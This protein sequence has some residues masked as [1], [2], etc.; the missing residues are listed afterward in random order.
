MS[1]LPS[2]DDHLL[3]QTDHTVLGGDVGG[4]AWR[5]AQQPSQRGD[6]HDHSA[7]A[8]LGHVLRC[9]TRTDEGSFQ[10]DRN[11]LVELFLGQVKDGH[12]RGQAGVVDPDIDPA[13]LAHCGINQAEHRSAVTGVRVFRDHPRTGVFGNLGRRFAALFASISPIKTEAPASASLLA[14]TL[15]RPQGGAGHHSIAVLQGDHLGQ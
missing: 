15:P 1:C 10:R 9:G 5:D 2:F 4:L 3:G 6:V 12:R 13:Q 11:D 8:R 7:R 14:A